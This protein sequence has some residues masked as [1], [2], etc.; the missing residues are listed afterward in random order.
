LS[1][2]VEQTGEARRIHGRRGTGRRHR[3]P[4][5]QGIAGFLIAC[6]LPGSA[7]AQS[8]RHFEVASI[9][10]N[11]SGQE[12]STAALL[13]GGRFT[14]TNQTIQWLLR[15]TIGVQDFQIAGPPSW[16][17]TD[18]FGIRSLRYS[19][20]GR[21]AGEDPAGSGGRIHDLASGG[22]VSVPVSS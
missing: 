7:F 6:V 15:V 11:N 22:T 19:G 2:G 10:P 18:R 3:I 16:V 8:P 20:E 4:V 14:A 21:Y 13:P 9:R 1:Q 5:R 12:R 17:S